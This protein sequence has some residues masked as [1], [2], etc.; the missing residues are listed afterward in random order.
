MEG[1]GATAEQ[2]PSP[3]EDG[4]QG[5]NTGQGESRA[6]GGELEPAGE[7][8][9]RPRVRVDARL[10][11]ATLLKAMELAVRQAP[12]AHLLLVGAA[13]DQAYMELVEQEILRRGLTLAS[14][15]QRWIAGGCFAAAAMV[16]VA[17]LGMAWGGTYGGQY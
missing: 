14:V 10:L 17:G 16:A 5:K 6:H 4:E 8:W 13:G 12:A 3:G 7:N 9:Q 2:S 11:E 1:M 15:H